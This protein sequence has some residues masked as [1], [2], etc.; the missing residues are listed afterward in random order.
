MAGDRKGKR[1]APPACMS[2]KSDAPPKKKV[3]KAAKG[4]RATKRQK[5]MEGEGLLVPDDLLSNVQ[6][7]HLFLSFSLFLSPSLSDPSLGRARLYALWEL[8]ESVGV[9]P[10]SR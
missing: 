10:C 1:R 2:V 3:K 5:Q 9:L 6:Q 8:R 4:E 7:V